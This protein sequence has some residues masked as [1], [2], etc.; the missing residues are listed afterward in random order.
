MNDDNKD[1]KHILNRILEPMHN[2]VLLFPQ[3]ATMGD[4]GVRAWAFKIAAVNPLKIQYREELPDVVANSALINA[5][6]AQYYG[7]ITK[8]TFNSNIESDDYLFVP[9]NYPFLIYHYAVGVAPE[10]MWLYKTYN[11]TPNRVLF[12]DTELVVGDKHDYIDGM[13]S[14]LKNPKV[15]AQDIVCKNLRVKYSFYNDDCEDERPSLDFLGAIYA[16]VPFT[17]EKEIRDLIFGKGVARRVEPVFGLRGFSFA[18]PDE[19]PK[20]ILLSAEDIAGVL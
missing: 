1:P 12:P 18:K 17:K 5:A 14:P 8:T 6:G 11:G 16:G 10:K 20:P 15:I 19:W 13:M 2:L 9:D 7:A 4:G 3:T